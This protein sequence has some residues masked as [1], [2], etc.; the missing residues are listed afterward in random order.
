[1]V[2]LLAELQPAENRQILRQ[3][4]D[5]GGLQEAILPVLAHQPEAADHDKFLHGLTSPKLALVRTCLE[6]LEKLPA[7]TDGPTLLAFIRGMRMLP[8]GKEADVLRSMFAAALK[9]RTQQ[10]LGPDKQKWTAWFERAYPELAKKLGGADG[11][12]VAAWQRRLAGID[13]SKGDSQRGKAVFQKASC[14]NCH[15][16]G[17][18][19]GPDLAGVGSRFSRE[20]LFTAIIQPSKDISPRYRTTQI[21]TTD[22]KT[23]QGLIVYEAVDGVILQT[24]PAETV[25]IDGKKIESRRLTDTSLMPVGLIDKLTDSEIADLYAFLRDWKR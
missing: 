23:Y 4:W 16:G 24:G 6:A 1:V 17:Q 12:D 19:M 8:E 2:S 14:V 20:D 5:R 7:K 15:S 13:W 21:E 11:V 25:R 3:L 9:K 18:A 22:G 10:D